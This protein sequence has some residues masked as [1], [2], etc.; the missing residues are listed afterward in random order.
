MG[1]GDFSLYRGPTL[2]AYARDIARAF[3]RPISEVRVEAR[4][5]VK[6]LLKDGM[7]TSGH[8]F[9]NVI[10]KKSGAKI[11]RVWF[12]VDKRKKRAFLYD[13]LINRSYRGK[14]YG[15]ETMQLLEGK[16]K[17]MGISQLG[18][19]VFA[20]NQIAINLY[21]NEGYYM[22]SYNMQKDLRS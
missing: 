22:A 7:A 12:N 5:Q 18:L 19:H 21:V 20:H 6:H 17:G 16:L 2:E 8:Y 14:G 4:K 15:R 10:E 1:E 3:H 11:G 13:I 9:L